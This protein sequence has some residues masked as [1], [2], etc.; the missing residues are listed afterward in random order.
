MDSKKSTMLIKKAVSARTELLEFLSDRRL[1][2]EDKTNGC[3]STHNML[4]CPGQSYGGSYEISDD[5]YSEFMDLY[6]E[7]CNSMLAANREDL[8][9]VEVPKP[10]SC[11]NGDLD[12]RQITK[13]RLYKRS[14]VT[15]AVEVYHKIIRKYVNIKDDKMLRTFVLEKDEPSLKDSGLFSDG[16]HIVFPY[17][18]ADKNLKLLITNEAKKLAEKM[19]IFGNIKLENDYDDIY[20]ISIFKNSKPT[21][22]LLYGCRKPSGGLYKFTTMYCGNLKRNKLKNNERLCDM[23]SMRKYKNNQSVPYDFEKYNE[24]ELEQII[25]KV[26]DSL[27]INKNKKTKN[28]KTKKISADDDIEIEEEYD[29]CAA[30]NI[31]SYTDEELTEREYEGRRLCEL[32]STE[33]AS[34]YETWIMVCWALANVGHKLKE[35]FFKFS[36]KINFNP[37]SC[38]KEWQRAIDYEDENKIGSGSLRFWAKKDNPDGFNE[39]LNDL[40]APYMKD[41]EDGSHSS[42]AKVLFQMYKDRFACA[43]ISKR[44]WYEFSHHHWILID[45]GY[46]LM[47]LISDEFASQF[48]LL[49]AQCIQSKND[50]RIIR[51]RFLDNEGRDHGRDDV[52][53]DAS[54]LMK[55][56]ANLKNSSFKEKI[57]S[58]C[59]RRFYV[60]DFGDLL[61]A[62][63]DLIGF[64]NGVYDLQNKCFREGLPEDYVTFSVGYDWK[65]YRD[66]H[67]Y[68][69]GI[70]DFFCKVQTDKILR[71]YVLNLLASHLTGQIL[72]NRFI[73]W[74]GHGC[75]AKG[76]EIRMIDGTIK[77]VEDIVTG[78]QLMGDDS[79]PRYVSKLFRG[80]DEMY[81]IIPRK[82]N[83]FVVN[84]NHILSL[85]ATNTMDCYWN[86]NESRFEFHWQEFNGNVPVNKYMNF[87]VRA[88]KSKLHK[89]RV[90]YYDT[91]DKALNAIALFKE[92]ICKKNSTIKYGDVIDIKLKDF[93]RVRK[94]I[95]I[96]NYYL[97]KTS[98]K[99]SEKK[100]NINPYM[101]GYWLGESNSNG[102]YITTTDD[103][104]IEYINDYQ[105]SK[106]DNTSDSYKE[107]SGN[108]LLTGLKKY[109]L[110][111]NKHIPSDFLYNSKENRLQLLAGLIDSDGCYQRSTKQYEI[112]L[113]DEQLLDSVIELARSLGFS[114]SKIKVLITAND[115][116]TVGYYFKC[117]I[118]GNNL[119][120]I[121]TKIIRKIADIGQINK[122]TVIVN[123]FDIE[124]IGE[125]EYYGFEVDKNHRYLTKDYYVHHNSNGKS[126]AIEFFQEAF[127]EYC[128]TVAVTLLTR[129]AGSSSSATPEI[130]GLRGKRFVVFQEPEGDDKIYVGNMKMFTGKDEIPA[131]PLYG[132]PIK[133]RPQFRMILTCNRLPTIPS[134]DDGTWRRI[135]VTPWESEFIDGDVDITDPEKQFRKDYKLGDKMS[136]WKG[137]FMWVLIKKHYEKNNLG[138]IPVSEPLA[139]KVS[140]K[141]YRSDTSFYN[142]F[143][144]ELLIHTKGSS[145]FIS[146][147]QL[148]DVFKDWYEENY[149]EKSP[150]RKELL[151]FFKGRRFKLNSTKLLEF[152]LREI[153]ED[154]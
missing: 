130:A 31:K 32:L 16:L 131:R 7:A 152:K 93:I 30:Y 85:K 12:F 88:Q 103:E 136:K 49:V 78:D 38:Q 62:N 46:T 108:I 96:R 79:T 6:R 105:L 21:G 113:K 2:K 106:I 4:P 66:D 42:I 141:E 37:E 82:G 144:D 97:Y 119:N 10:V 3:E 92:D 60:R 48:T 8:Y 87:A 67:P 35:D 116:G 70:N 55:I 140:T 83:S 19:D 89:T 50:N 86:E 45:G 154:D 112:T 22:W 61:D 20:D 59:A 63:R 23:L 13:S 124:H 1:S 111:N 65:E 15:K 123:N 71:D 122:K 5:D 127:G 117:T 100:I 41:A 57:M 52:D 149:N 24:E 56:I 43:S 137:A 44:K 9:I 128:D 142:Q 102:A 36:E 74:T 26:Y 91:K 76:S 17:I 18:P 143:M 133:F 104:I 110:L 72:S 73:I 146:I 109:N 134:D 58:E 99:Y 148:N 118:R 64:D 84:Q 27:G 101:L 14:H 53:K 77:K 47:N 34:K 153:Q 107:N 80:K 139:V 151:N 40:I 115:M 69:V 120:E 94:N 39:L 95:G 132:E 150:P 33:R 90:T 28:K 54:R 135:R 145:D 75:H 81:K 147:S 25:N 126:T 129:K 51:R 11:L 98:V 121:P 114:A 138:E 125:G 29:Y 68:V